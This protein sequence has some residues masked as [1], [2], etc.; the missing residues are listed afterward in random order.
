MALGSAIRRMLGARWARRTAGWY[1]A[2][3][4]D[5]A[6][7]AAAIASALP[8]GTHLLDI[9]GG[10]GEPLNYLLALR[11]DL[12][13]TTIDPGPVAGQWV[14]PRF[15]SRVTRLPRTS[16]AEYLAKVK[17]DPDAILIADVMHHIPESA[18]AGFL[19]SVKSLLERAP[20]LRIIVKDVEPGSWRALLGYWSD[21]YI[22][23]DLHVS[24]ISRAQVVRLFDETLGPLRREDTNLF[25]A[26][27]PNYAITFFR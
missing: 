3:F 4:V 20:M 15:D 26:N 11:P 5:L 13:I 25:N 2:I 16:L 23:G 8:S 10:D 14:E 19:D 6:K 22:T 24:P 27:R 9:G 12:S 21:R 18:R 17:A 1:R 7:E